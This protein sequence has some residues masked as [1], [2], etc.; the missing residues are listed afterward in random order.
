MD[1]TM[2][3]SVSSIVDHD[4]K[5]RIYVQFKDRD[6]TA[7][8]TCPKGLV[9]SNEGF[10]EKELAAL[11]FYVQENKDLIIEAAQNVNVLDAFMNI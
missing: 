7:E 4:G 3:M 6:R 1:Q 11:R 10:T 2:E 5:K 8:L 9:V